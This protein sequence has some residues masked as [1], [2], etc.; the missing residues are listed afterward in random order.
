[1]F[2]SDNIYSFRGQQSTLPEVSISPRL[3]GRTSPLWSRS[4]WLL[5]SSHRVAI[6]A[7]STR[8]RKGRH[9][10]GEKPCVWISIPLAWRD[11]CLMRGYIIYCWQGQGSISIDSQNPQ[12]SSRRGRDYPCRISP[13]LPSAHSI[14]GESPSPMQP[15]LRGKVREMKDNGKNQKTSGLSRYTEYRSNRRA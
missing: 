4:R 6:P 15:S 9:L 7:T 3:A 13:F 14:S 8:T 5:A 1:M 10:N 2:V 11:T 12:A